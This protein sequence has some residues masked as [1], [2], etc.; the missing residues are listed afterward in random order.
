MK[1]P[2][3]APILVRKIQQV[4]N[5]SFSIDWSDGKHSMYR[6]SELQKQCPC[7]NCVDENTGKRLSDDKMVKT[8]VRAIRIA[9]VGRYALRIQFTSGCST[10]IFS[11]NLLRKIDGGG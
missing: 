2:S 4:D 1:N 7:A 6:L 9:S 3:S 5:H 11:F 8:D 10:G